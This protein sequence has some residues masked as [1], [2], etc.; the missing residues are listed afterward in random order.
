MYFKV[1][2]LSAM[3]D[4]FDTENPLAFMALVFWHDLRGVHLMVAIII[5]LS[6]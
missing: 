5:Y 1:C 2:V 6:F 3:Y 4:K